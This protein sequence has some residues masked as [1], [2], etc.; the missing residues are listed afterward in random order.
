MLKKLTRQATTMG[1]KQTYNLKH[2]Y[3]NEYVSQS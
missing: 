2:A 1:V 3:E